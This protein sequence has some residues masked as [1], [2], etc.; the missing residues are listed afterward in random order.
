MVGAVGGS[1]Y[2]HR[3]GDQLLQ[4]DSRHRRAGRP[5]RVQRLRAE[6]QPSALIRLRQG[7]GGTGRAFTLRSIVSSRSTATV[8]WPPSG[9]ITSAWRL[10]GSTNSRCIGFTVLW[11]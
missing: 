10:L 4:V 6:S 8:L 7:Y 1:W 2:R 11:Y 5:R 3:V 9:M